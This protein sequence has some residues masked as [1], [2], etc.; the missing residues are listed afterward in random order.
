N[1]HNVDASVDRQS[2]AAYV[3]RDFIRAIDA[4]DCGVASWMMRPRDGVAELAP[5]DI[6]RLVAMH[7]P[8]PA[9]EAVGDGRRYDNAFEQAVQAATTWLERAAVRAAA[10]AVADELLPQQGDD[11]IVRLER[12]VPWRGRT[13][14]HQTHV[15]WPDPVDGGWLAQAI[16][17]EDD[18]MV[19]KVAYPGGWIGLG[20]EELA[21]VSGVQDAVFARGH[22]AG[23]RSR[24]GVE[25]MVKRAREVT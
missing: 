2:I 23:A 9:V 18:P 20:A 19:P 4:V 13:L 1:R 10:E 5:I 12:L 16:G 25:A 21:R 17:R 24:E 14:A 3:D 11:T 15:M 7:N 8:E 6:P 22:V